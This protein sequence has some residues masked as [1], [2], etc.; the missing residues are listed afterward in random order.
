M[1]RLELNLLGKDYFSMK[2]AAHYCCVSL[3]QFKKYA[4]E[5]KIIPTSHMGKLLYRRADLQ[6]SIEEAA[7]WQHS[8]G[9]K[10]HGISN[11]NNTDNA[12]KRN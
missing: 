4:K 3:S 12:T 8:T 10:R 7:E 5:R 2:E 9:I 11:G 1:D 6:R